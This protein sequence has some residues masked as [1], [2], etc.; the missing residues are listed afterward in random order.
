MRD[1]KLPKGWLEVPLPDVV[2]FQE[3][4]GL[5]KYQYRETGIPFLNIRT[6][7]DGKV[8]KSLCHCLDLEEVESK[9]PHFLLSEGDI[10]CSTSG[11]IGKTAL[12]RHE[13]LANVKYKHHSLSC[14]LRGWP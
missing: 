6:I 3:G 5:R 11:T 9:Y 1:K 12:I 7:V 13:D 4:P 10:I 14:S 8:D 2:F